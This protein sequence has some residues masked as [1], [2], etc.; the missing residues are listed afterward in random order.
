M[1][2]LSTR[3]WLKV[4]LRLKLRVDRR[5]GLMVGPMVRVGDGVKLKV[6][7]RYFGKA[8]TV[9]FT[10]RSGRIGRARASRAGALEFGPWSSLVNDL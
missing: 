10:R 4:R 2:R 3:A 1:V 6:R 7:A 5:C 8:L 9:D